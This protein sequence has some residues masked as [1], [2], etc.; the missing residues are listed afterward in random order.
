MLAIFDDLDT[1]LLMIPLQ[2]LM[3]GLKWQMFAIVGV[4]VVL[5]IAGW[6]WQAR[7]NV[8]QDWKRILV[9]RSMQS[10]REVRVR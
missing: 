8:R 9:M 2:I 4:V 10:R 6:R 5:L 7:W 3:I 1:I